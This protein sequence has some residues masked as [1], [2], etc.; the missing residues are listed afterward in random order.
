MFE[1]GRRMERYLRVIDFVSEWT[2]KG[3]SFLLVF[4]I[5]AIGYD[6]TVRYFFSIPNFWIYDSTYMIY[7][8]YTMLGVAFCHRN[9]G[10]VRMDLF[11][12]RLSPKGQALMDVVCY[13]VLFFPLMGV[14]TYKCADYTWW[15]IV[16]GERSS[17]SAWR[18]YLGPF[19]ATVTFGFILFFLQG[20]AEFLRA[21]SV[22]VKGRASES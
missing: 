12:S 7:G 2:G 19:N 9:R 21:L 11:Y 17:A 22:L 13:I 15:S 1:T 20:V 18:P 3:A 5:A 16:Q 4:L 6:I 14:L 8:A 10:H